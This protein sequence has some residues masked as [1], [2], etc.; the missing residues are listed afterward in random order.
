MVGGEPM[1]F[2]ELVNPKDDSTDGTDHFVYVSGMCCGL[3][4]S[5]TCAPCNPL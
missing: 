2:S 5:N 3:A 4:G 1:R